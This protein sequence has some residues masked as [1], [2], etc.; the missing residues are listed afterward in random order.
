VRGIELD[1]A[2][3]TA[4]VQFQRKDERKGRNMKLWKTRRDGQSMVEFA[5]LLPL[6]ALLLFAIIQYGFIFSAYMTL[7]HAANVT[8]RTVG[9]ASLTPADATAVAKQAI[10][11][12][13]DVS[14]LGAVTV[15]QVSV[16]TLNDSY[17]VQLTYTLPLI[18]KFVVPGA[19]GNTLVLNARAIYRR[20]GNL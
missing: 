17:S 12:M 8:A 9:L 4:Y 2:H 16:N 18:I 3:E 14:K 15:N 10:T 13:L 7:R 11:P 6:L 5:L 19:S 1:E 20:E